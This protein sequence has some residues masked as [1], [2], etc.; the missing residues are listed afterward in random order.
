M[1]EENQ[2]NFVVGICVVHSNNGNFNADISHMPRRLPDQNGTIY[3]T[4]KALKYCIRRYLKEVRNEKIFMWRRLKDDKK[5]MDINENY[6]ELF[7]SPNSNQNGRKEIED[8]LLSCIDVRLFGCTYA[9]N[10]NISIHGTTQLTYGI[11]KLDENVIYTNQILSPFRNL[12]EKSKDDTQTTMG[13]ESKSLDV[14]YVYD[15]NINPRNLDTNNGKLT[16][17]DVKKFKEA[18]CLGV[19]YV[20]STT[21][22]GSET[23]LV[24]H[25]ELKEPKILQNLKKFVKITKKQNKMEI[26]LSE[27]LNYAKK[28]EGS[29]EKV[30]IYYEKEKTDII[31]GE[32]LK[33]KIKKYES[34]LMKEIQNK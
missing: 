8:N 25:I 34:L 10:E 33:E 11:N 27:I 23:L 9:G 15:Y 17:E 30:E 4:D 18:L 22:I 19:N 16:K 26:D 28:F 20:N 29:I 13:E 5:P 24:M 32:I 1:T 31:L 21:K 6:K 14:C 12:N 2:T 7:K 3:A